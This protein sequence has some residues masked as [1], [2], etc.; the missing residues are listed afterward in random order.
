MG[1]KMKKII[2]TTTALILGIVL[3][4]LGAYQGGL[5]EEAKSSGYEVE[6]KI[7]DVVVEEEQD[8]DMIYSYNTYTVYV[9][10]TINGK[11]YTNVRVGKYT[12]PKYV[13]NTIT[14]VVNPEKPGSAISEGGIFT[15]FGFVII[16]VAIV[17][18]V[19]NKRAE[20]E[21]TRNNNYYNQQSENENAGER[22]YS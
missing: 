13:G 9:D 21:L 12:E 7:V 22:Y 6:A 15:T 14:V 18:K 3:F 5:Y 11:D 1:K 4:I 2:N 20:K 10:Y 19:K 16:V 8:S 17:L